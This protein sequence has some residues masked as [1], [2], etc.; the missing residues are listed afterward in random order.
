MAVPAIDAQ[1]ARNL[2][3]LYDDLR[4]YVHASWGF[5][6]QFLLRLL[7]R[8]FSARKWGWPNPLRVLWTGYYRLVLV[9]FWPILSRWMVSRLDRWSTSPYNRSLDLEDFR[10]LLS[11]EQQSSEHVPEILSQYWP[12]EVARAC[13]RRFALDRSDVEALL[14]I[15]SLRLAGGPIE[16]FAIDTGKA[17]SVAIAAV[18]IVGSLVPQQTY[19]AIGLGHDYG[20]IR[21]VIILV[22]VGFAAYIAL[23]NG[24]LG[25]WTRKRRRVNHQ[26]SIVLTYCSIV[27][28]A[29]KP[30]IAATPTDK[31]GA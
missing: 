1:S 3:G 27:L 24:L 5:R 23:V 16:S 26:M 12:E 13:C 29:P 7:S 8:R 2:T 14:K 19:A 31:P 30:A 15:D 10:E 4:K 6:E 28:A 18:G 20:V 22:A 9:L 21:G 11:T 17:F 25:G